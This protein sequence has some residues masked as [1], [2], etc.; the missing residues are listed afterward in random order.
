MKFLMLLTMVL[1]L[2]ACT[3]QGHVS[4]TPNINDL[5]DNSNSVNFIDKGNVKRIVDEKYDVVC[6]TKKFESSPLSCVKM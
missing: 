5:I 4:Q 2:V 1:S 3:V 6:Y